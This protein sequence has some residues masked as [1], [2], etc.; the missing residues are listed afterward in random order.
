MTATAAPAFTDPC[1]PELRFMS[2]NSQA[3]F[4]LD[5]GANPDTPGACPV[6]RLHPALDEPQSRVACVAHTR[7]ALFTVRR[8]H[9]I[10]R[11]AGLE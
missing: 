2:L 1:T 4:R 3:L 6:C 7:R 10:L 11:I 5:T 8:D 9:D